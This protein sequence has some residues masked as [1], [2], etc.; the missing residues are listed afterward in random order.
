MAPKQLL[1]KN[2]WEWAKS[3]PHQ[4]V[5]DQH[6]QTAYRIHLPPCGDD[7]CKKN[8]LG[9]PNCLRGL[10]EKDWLNPDVDLLAQFV[11]P[12]EYFRKTEDFV[13]L[14]NLGATCYINAYLQV[15]YHNHAFRNAILKWNERPTGLLQGFAQSERHTNEHL[16]P[17][18]LLGQ[19][20]LIF[21][22]LRFGTRKSFAPSDFIKAL[23][24][25]T[26]VQQD[27]Q[28]F[29]KLLMTKLQELDPEV[30]RTIEKQF[31]GKCAYVTRCLRCKREVE[32]DSTFYEL[33][34]N[35]QD[36]PDLRH[37]LEEYVKK[38]DLKDRN[39]YNCSECRRPTDATHGVQ[40][41]SLPPVLNFQLQRFIYENNQKKKL[42]SYFAFEE[43]LDMRD[44]VPS[45]REEDTIY[46][47]TAIVMHI[48]SSAS[49]GHYVALIKDPTTSETYKFNDDE[50]C[51]VDDNKFDISSVEDKDGAKT[52]RPKV[53]KG[54]ITS[55]T[56][57]MLVYQ[58]RST[59]EDADIKEVTKEDLP[60]HVRLFLESDKEEFE[61]EV[62]S[63]QEKVSERMEFWQDQHGV[64]YGDLYNVADKLPRKSTTCTT[65]HTSCEWVSRSWL[66]KWMNAKDPNDIPPVIDTDKFLCKHKKLHPCYVENVK[67]I[68]TAAADKICSLYYS[69]VRLPCLDALCR[70]CVV[71]RC[72][73]IHN[74]ELVIDA[75]HTIM[76]ASG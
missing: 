69:S 41:K 29:C 67:L 10:G 76:A 8:C 52:K 70:E 16:T 2:A 28:E 31:V 45:D 56:A 71:G 33:V 54:M 21:A 9:N 34:L 61:T 46:D 15:W 75:E 55:R 23:K 59:R 39:Q 22:R 6:I 42:N 14:D 62:K 53:K 68:P 73:V 63:T 11:E 30:R 72:Y 58:L 48:G 26:D 49:S 17:A 47:L 24:I 40:L 1:E 43:T 38:S 66:T 60:E 37:S 13:G 18:S 7:S 74:T 20:Q 50:V 51:K 64:I 19:L 3:T 12:Q 5:T 27:A 44:F 25:D 35:V 32:N 57:Y 65:R 4:N 36:H